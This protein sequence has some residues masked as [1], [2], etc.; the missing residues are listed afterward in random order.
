MDIL[1]NGNNAP[2]SIGG[3]PYPTWVAVVSRMNT[4]RGRDYL[5]PRY[6][7]ETFHLL[8]ETGRRLVSELNIKET[9]AGVPHI[10][11]YRVNVE[12]LTG[13]VTVQVRSG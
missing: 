9:L 2:N 3:V 13:Q 7:L 10:S 12:P 1:Y 4:T 8:D 5:N 6:G 11:G